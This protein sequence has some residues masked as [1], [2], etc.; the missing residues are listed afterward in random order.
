MFVMQKGYELNGRV[1][2]PA[3]VMVAK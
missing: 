3:M 2:R 1:I